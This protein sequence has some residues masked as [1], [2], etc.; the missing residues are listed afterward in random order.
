MGNYGRQWDRMDSVWELAHML[1]REVKGEICIEP[2]GFTDSFASQNKICFL[3][4]LVFC[5]GYTFG[6]VW[7]VRI[8]W[9]GLPIVGV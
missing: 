2:V 6:M 3:F 1:G 9:R 8:P 4:V 5:C 7:V